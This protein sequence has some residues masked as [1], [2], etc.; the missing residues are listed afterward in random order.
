MSTASSRG[1]TIKLVNPKLQLGPTQQLIKPVSAATEPR[2]SL[3]S[4]DVQDPILAAVQSVATGSASSEQ[5]AA[6]LKK[7][8]VAADERFK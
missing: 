3:L 8:A 1:T 6:T 2:E 5:A 7:A 4:A